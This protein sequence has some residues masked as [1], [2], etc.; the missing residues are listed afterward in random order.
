MKFE[1][2]SFVIDNVLATCRG[3]N[4]ENAKKIPWILMKIGELVVIVFI[5]MY[6]KFQVKILMRT[7]FFS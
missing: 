7:L 6:L 2:A 5:E 4:G 1:L 3:C